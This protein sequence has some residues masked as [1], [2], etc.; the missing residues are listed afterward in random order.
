MSYK[1][2][3]SSNFK[4]EAKKLYKKFPSLKTE[5]AHLF[6][7]LENDPFLGTPMGGDIIK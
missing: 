2:E 3:L 7:V 5:L 6:D 1:V 4:K